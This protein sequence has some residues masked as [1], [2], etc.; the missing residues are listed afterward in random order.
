MV[1]TEQEV[2]HVDRCGRGKGRR[3]MDCAENGEDRAM[4]PKELNVTL[5]KIN[6]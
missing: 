6:E 1:R 3:K 4:H 5:A 2:L